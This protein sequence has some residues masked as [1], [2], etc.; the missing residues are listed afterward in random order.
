MRIP[1]PHLLLLLLCLA[2]RPPLPP[3]LSAIELLLI[4]A[5]K[6]WSSHPD[7]LLRL[8]LL[9]PCLPS[10]SFSTRPLY[11]Q[12]FRAAILE[13]SRLLHAL[14]A[15]CTLRATRCL[16]SHPRYQSIHPPRCG[17][18]LSHSR[19]ALAVFHVAAG[20]PP[21][22]LLACLSR[23]YHVVCVRCGLC[24]RNFPCFHVFFSFS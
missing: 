4:V 16:L 2:A 12:T 10:C 11:F 13:N 21:T 18:F 8:P 9:W 6:Q 14:V 3:I 20:R 15:L 19:L 23:Q 17:L 7:Y 24:Q 1:H 5:F 22:I